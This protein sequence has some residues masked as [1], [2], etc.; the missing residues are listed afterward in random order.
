M[1]IVI[2]RRAVLDLDNLRQYLAPKSRT[3]LLNVTDALQNA[4]KDIPESLSRG[5]ATPHDDVWEKVVP[6]YG[7]IIPYYVRGDTVFILRIYNSRR[8]PLNYDGLLDLE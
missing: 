5:R 6:K 1:K 8:K 4:I 2:T 3:E 7:Y